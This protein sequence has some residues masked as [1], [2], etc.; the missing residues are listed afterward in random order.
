MTSR[1]P[2]P[3]WLSH[4]Q[5]GR[6]AG[7]PAF[8]DQRTVAAAER[9][10]RVCASFHARSRQLPSFVVFPNREE[11]KDFRGIGSF[12]RER[13]FLGGASFTIATNFIIVTLVLGE[14][15][16]RGGRKGKRYGKRGLTLDR[17]RVFTFECVSH[18]N[19]KPM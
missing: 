3:V 6:R 2:S 9:S 4:R 5:A 19:D 8:A 13:I 11:G 12:P 16:K 7:G 17:E 14:K 10:R 18:P 1:A 15:R